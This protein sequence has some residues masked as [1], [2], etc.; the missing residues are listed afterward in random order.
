M[1]TLSIIA[2]LIAAMNA[3]DTATTSRLL[4]VL[5]TRLSPE[6]VI[7]V[8]EAILGEEVGALAAPLV[9]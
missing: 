8:L 3:N 9:A 4:G 6:E 1:A 7:T 2:D 5:D